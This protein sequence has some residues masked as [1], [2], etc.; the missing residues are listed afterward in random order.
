[1]AKDDEEKVFLGCLLTLLIMPPAVLFRGFVLTRL[2][3]WFV[4]P[5]GAPTVG[6]AT[7]IGLTM[8]GSMLTNVRRQADGAA[9]SA[10]DRVLNSVA[11]GFVLPAMCW[12]VG[13]ACHLAA[14][15]GY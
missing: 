4:V 1:M 12:L 2:W 7:A 15:A 8:I 14:T 6:I 11:Y 5:F 10:T 9:E 3:A 13:W